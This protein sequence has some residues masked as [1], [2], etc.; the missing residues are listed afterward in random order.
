MKRQENGSRPAALS[1]RLARISGALTWTVIGL[2]VILMA[3]NSLL[4][5]LFEAPDEVEHFGFI[6]HLLNESG[7]P[8]QEANGP[9][10]QSHQ[11]PLYYWLGA[12][13]ISGVEITVA[14][15]ERNPF[16]TSYYRDRVHQDNKAQ[17]VP[18]AEN[19]FPYTGTALAMHLLRLYSVV[20]AALTLLVGRAIGRQLW[21]DRPERTLMLVSLVAFN[22]MFIYI[23]SALNNDNL[24]N[25]FGALVILLTLRAIDDKFSWPTTLLLGLCWTGALLSKL[26][27]LFLPISWGVALLLL[28]WRQR[29]LTLLLARGAAIGA[30]FLTGAGWWF[31]RNLAVYGEPFAL[32]RTIEVWGARE[33]AARNL[34]TFAAE[35]IYIWTNFWGRFGYGQVTMPNWIYWLFLIMVV[36]AAASLLWHGARAIPRL[37]LRQ[38]SSWQLKWLVL[39]ATFAVYV[40]ALGYYT[41][42]NATGAN[43]R[44]IYPAIF[45]GA[46]LLTRGWSFLDRPGRAAVGISLIMGLVAIYATLYL[47]PWTFARP[48]IITVAEARARVNPAKTAQWVNG[49]ELLGTAFVPVYH[50]DERGLE[51]HSTACFTSASPLD[52]DLVFFVH[53]LDQD[54]NPLGQRDSYTGRGNYPTSLWE[55]GE[56][57][58]ER[59]AVPVI[60]S[61]VPDVVVADIEIGFYH[62]ATRERVPVTYQGNQLDLLFIDRV[63]LAPE[64]LPTR[65]PPEIELIAEFEE[66]IQLLGY[67]WSEESLPS[68]TLWWQS[69][70]P[71]NREYQVFAQLVD[72]SGFVFAQGDGPPQNGT[73][74]TTLWG[75]GDIIIDTHSFVL[76]TEMRPNAFD[77]ATLY[78][79]LYRL[80]DGVRLQRV[81][82]GEPPDAVAI[83]GPE[84]R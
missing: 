41:Y 15:P 71:L 76:G 53:L 43:G 20:L 30:I 4:H 84:E 75:K 77:G 23:G 31:V 11:T 24:V 62:R 18:T 3:A 17:F 82:G 13:L 73:Y 32:N 7:L 68:I 5:P 50:E 14:T 52:E 9:P 74:P 6:L 55:P 66:G 64:T 25:L 1:Q 48:E 72:Q 39:T 34:E 79:G 2:S 27:G 38:L 21:R 44:Y 19:R 81:D 70:G 67:E 46:A 69:Q 16:W 63:R 65:R 26:T 28:A 59:L 57:F 33:A 37:S 61:M 58:C 54:L 49:I 22:P 29:A 35:G 78:V 36:P 45:A 51:L 12:G 42:Q 8:I 40:A 56:A 60:Q 83:P 47:G 10:S 80:E